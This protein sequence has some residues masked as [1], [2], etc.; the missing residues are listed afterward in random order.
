MKIISTPS[1]GTMTF[2]SCDWQCPQDWRLAITIPPSKRECSRAYQL[3]LRHAQWRRTD[4][5]LGTIHAGLDALTTGTVVFL[6]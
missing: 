6:W 5:F 3:G 4:C 2:A 1:T